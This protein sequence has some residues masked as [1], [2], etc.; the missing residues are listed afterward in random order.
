LAVDASL[1]LDAAR[2]AWAR[3]AVQFFYMGSAD[4]MAPLLAR[5]EAVGGPA[6]ATPQAAGH[7][8]EALAVRGDEV[9][10]IRFGEQA[11]ASFEVAGDERNACTLRIVVGFGLNELGAY[12]RAVPILG[13]ALASAER[14]ALHNVQAVA[15]AQLG[16]AW[17]CSGDLDGAE[18]ALGRALTAFRGQGN[19]LMEGAALTYL[20]ATAL[21]RGDVAGAERHAL[22]AIAAVGEGWMAR[23][24]AEAAL[25]RVRLAQGAPLEAVAAA[26][27]ALAALARTGERAPRRGLIRLALAEALHGAGKLDEARAALR[28]ARDRIVARAAELDESLRADFLGAQPDH[29][30]T[31][32]W[33]EEWQVSS[34]S[35]GS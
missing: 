14:L 9:A 7:I 5:V 13:A 10:R 33:A 17:S 3:T 26:R 25:A 12:R 31:L 20:A 27:A 35:S 1:E 11:I 22:A 34:A 8:Y 30:R 2:I 23:A 19:L 4:R 28:D 16:H 29:A 18:G 15:N 21:A 24:A 32:R 6:A